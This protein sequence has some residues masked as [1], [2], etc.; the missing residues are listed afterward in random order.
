MSTPPPAPDLTP[1]GLRATLA[2]LTGEDVE[3]ITD[4]VSLFELGLD[5]ITLMQLANGWR[6][7]GLD[8]DFARLAEQPTVS[9]WS[10]LL[11][12][13][14][15]SAAAPAVAPP[16]AAADPAFD[17]ALMQHAYWVGRTEGQPL[18]G[19]AAHLYTEFDSPVSDSSGPGVDP[20]RL[21]AALDALL[22][23][24]DMLR[25]RVSDDGR[26]EI[27]PV[28]PD[29]GR[30]RLTVHDLRG[31]RT[32]EVEAAL[33]ATRDALSHQQLDIAGGEVLTAALS[34]LPDGRTRLHLD[35]DMVAADAVSY[36]ILLA[37]LARLYRDPGA[38]LPP[39]GLTYRDYLAARRAQGSAEGE[40]A[41]RH[42][43]ERLAELPGAPDLPL[44]ADHPVPGPARVVRRHLLLDETER[45]ALAEGARRHGVTLAAAVATA[46]A[47]VLG[48]WSA[49]PRFLLNVP[50]FDRAPLHP[51]VER[52]VGDFTSSVLLA[53]DL[54]EPIPFADRARAVRARL[55]AD[56]AHAPHSGVEVLRDLTRARGEQ[57][58]APVVFTSA[59]NLGELFGEIVH[60]TFGE[61]VWI[62]SQ[63]PQVLLDAQVTELH[64]G[65][66]VNW[67]VRVREFAPGVVDAMFAAFA[68]LVRRLGTEPAA[69]EEPAG[70][71]VPPGQLAVRAAINDAA[72]DPGWEPSRRLLHE[73]FFAV[74]ARRPDAPAVVGDH[75]T[76]TYGEL[77]DRA[78]RTAG[79]LVGRGVRPGDLVGVTLSK[80]PDQVVAVLGVL[81]AGAGYVPVGV[82]QPQAR[83]ER[84]ASVAGFDVVLDRDTLAAATTAEPLAAPVPSD[85]EQIAYVLFTSGSTGEPKGVEVPHRAAMNTVEDLIDRYALGPADR[86]LAISALDFDLSVFDIAAPLSVGGAVVTVGEDGRREAHA[87]ARLIREHR[88]TVLNCVPPL[89]DMLLR[90]GERLGDSMRVV[91]LGGDRVGVDLPGRLREQVPGCRFV[92]LGGT[93]ETA[94]HSTV[95]E[96]VDAV[97]PPD[98]QSV[99]YGRPLRGV[100]MRVV[101]GQGRDVPDWVP[102]ELWIGGAG[103]AH[104]YRGDPVRTADRFLTRDDGRWYRTGDLARYRP[105]G[106]V[107]FLGRRDDQVKIRG[108]RIELGEVEAAL[109]AAGAA[110]AVAVVVDGSL[111]AGVLPAVADGTPAPDALRSAVRALL[112]P[113]M[114]PERVVA[115]SALPL[116]ANGKVDRRAVR[117]LVGQAGAGDSGRVAPSG[118]VEWAIATIWAEALGRSEPVGTTEEFFALGGDSLIAT[119][120]VADLRADLGAGTAS[121]RTLLGAPTVARLAARL[122]ADDPEPERLRRAAEIFCELAELSDAEVAA[123]LANQL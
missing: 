53:V 18:G 116:T 44:A 24:H 101:D 2:E 106:T 108:F 34:L 83:A 52:L 76:L 99:P 74:A 114:V 119:E 4:D 28:D 27:G 38:V 118:P 13:G 7:A 82:E 79:W 88:V 42:W 85:P 78:F 64:G 121:V 40:R 113:H 65:L 89:L 32:T 43:R 11:S 31:L 15:G 120:I 94:I 49:Q 47:E 75:E 68:D 122:L 39:I 103:V 48:A 70:G 80:G 37:E 30:R 63:G 92:G 9:A 45:A 110:A 58:L 56:T 109:V 102:G 50:L 54:S 84:I 104:G 33:T 95:C 81:A 6:R 97:V 111:A 100:R 41:A 69:W 59:L 61:A 12:G 73:G 71:L 93:T 123:Q 35:V 46:F 117:Q 98:W 90:S 26:Q 105:D 1:D 77:A 115:L 67:D 60:E 87:W 8:V 66:L 36:R 10:A 112:P 55:H 21:A 57:V 25:V 107:E 86:T 72:T 16:T 5:S 17:L 20:E 14:A 51:D 19:V 96:V 62:I 91:L 29:A 22:A 3:D 23:R